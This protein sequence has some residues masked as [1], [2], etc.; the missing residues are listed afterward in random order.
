[1]LM[2]SYHW[3]S[4]YP[5]ALVPLWEWMYNNPWHI[6]RYHCNYCF[7]KWSTCLE[8]GLPPFPLPHPMMNG[9]FYYQRWLLY[10]DGYC[11]YWPNL[12]KYGVVNFDD[13]NTC[14]DYGYSKED[15]ILCQM[16]TKWWLH[17][18]CYWDLWVFSF[19][20]WFIFYHLCTNHY[21][22]SLAVF[23]GPVNAHFPL[24][25]VCP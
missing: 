3:Q 16:N 5:F 23:F 1:M 20:F 11:H 14:K 19:S 24:S 13:N 15:M 22:M 2:W 21:Y 6:S 17:S 12:H 9:Y 4:K 8:R 10:F 7:G 18:P 25:R